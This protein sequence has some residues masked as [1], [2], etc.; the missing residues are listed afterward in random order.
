MSTRE[1]L[2]ALDRAEDFFWTGFRLSSK[3]GEVSQ[4][5]EMALTLT[6]IHAYQTALGQG[7]EETSAIAFGLLGNQ[8]FMFLCHAAINRPSFQIWR[9]RLLYGERWG[10]P[11]M[12]NS[13]ILATT[14]LGQECQQ[15]DPL[16]HPLCQTLGV[17]SLETNRMMKTLIPELI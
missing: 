14:L 10:R 4:M 2:A 7:K 8:L 9:L 1:I 15:T 16:A 12:A 11:S 3:R 13:G 6:L 5:R 17:S